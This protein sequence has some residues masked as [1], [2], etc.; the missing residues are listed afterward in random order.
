[1]PPLP[2]LDPE[3]RD[4]A[5]GEP[6]ILDSRAGERTGV[7]LIRSLGVGGMSSVF[8]ARLD[9]SRRR[10]PGAE[11]A[12]FPERMAVKIVKPSVVDDLAQEGHR[13]APS[14]TAGP[15]CWAG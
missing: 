13:R 5:A 8:L 3:L 2:S 12:R 4:L 11:G 10:H 14:P 7:R 6:E 1:M 9:P 15:P